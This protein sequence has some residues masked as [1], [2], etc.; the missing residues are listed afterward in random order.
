M[1]DAH[2][3]VLP[4]NLMLERICHTATVR[5]ATL[6]A[7]HPTQAMVRGYHKTPAKTH[8]MPLQKLLECFKIKPQCFETIMPD[9]RP[10]T[11]KRVFT[12]TIAESKEES[13]KD[14]EKDEADIKVYT[15]G[16]GYEGNVGAAAV[17]Y[18]KGAEEPEKILRYHLGP[19]TKHTTFEG[20]AVGSILAAWMLQGRQEVGK[21]TVTSYTDSQA[22]I[23]STGVRKSGSGQYLVMEYLRLTEI[24]T[25]ETDTPT[26]ADT[27]KFTLKWV[28][29]HKGVAGNERV[30][31]EAKRAAQGDSSP[32]EELPPALQKRLPT[33]ASAVKQKF[34]D[35]L[36][37]RWAETWKTSPRYAR[38]QHIN[39]DFPF[40]KFRK[41][42]NALSRPQASLLTQLQTGHVPL[43]SYLYRIKKSGT[44]R[45]ES[46][47]AVGQIETV[48]TVVHYLFECQAYTAERYDM[49]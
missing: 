18:R 10:P 30:D 36:K 35:K 6:P 1:L 8:L 16:S 17:L 12:T 44:R 31:E 26:P 37:V 20:E 27:D 13:I 9:P 3:R 39:T 40:N 19:L 23:K 32:P 43:N 42:N 33:S 11:Y 47:W 24:M 49:D 7:S 34:T 21:A 28:A 48:E 46:C 45:C 22:F 2:A 38:F 14:E 41:I 15:D 25:D 5:A 29:A 4:A